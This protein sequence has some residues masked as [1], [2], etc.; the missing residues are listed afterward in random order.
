MQDYLD[1]HSKAK[2]VL[3]VVDRLTPR[4]PLNRR[5]RVCATEDDQRDRAAQIELSRTGGHPQVVTSE[6]NADVRWL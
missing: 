1:G 5:R 6:T 2:G 3:P 4:K